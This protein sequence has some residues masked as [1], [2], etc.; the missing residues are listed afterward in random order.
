MSLSYDSTNSMYYAEINPVDGDYISFVVSDIAVSQPAYYR[1][2]SSATGTDGATSYPSYADFIA[3]T[4]GTFI[5]FTNEWAFVDSFLVDGSYFYRTNNVIDK[6]TRYP[7]IEDMGAATNG[8]EYTLSQTWG[9]N[10]EFFTDG[11]N[12]YR[13]GS[14]STTG[15]DAITTHPS[16][17]DLVANTNGVQT[18]LNTN[19][20]FNDQLTHDGQYFLRTNVSATGQDGVTRYA[21]L[22]DFA[23]N[24]PFDSQDFTS[25]GNPQE[26]AFNDDIYALGITATFTINETSLTI[27]EN[28]GTGSFTIV[29]DA[30]PLT[31]V[32]FDISSED[33]GEATVSPT[34]LTFTS[35]D[36]NAAQTVTVTGVDDGLTATHTG[37]ITISVNDT[38]SYD[39]FDSLADKLVALTLTD[40]DVIV[41]ASPG[42]VSAGLE[43]W[44]K[45]G[46]GTNV[47]GSN[48]L[49][50][51]GG[52]A[53]LDQSG[54]ARHI[55]FIGDT[56]QLQDNGVNFN[57]V[58]DWNGSDFGRHDG[59]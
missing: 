37:T 24:I 43:F 17:T 29:L 30:Q 33:T 26:W 20:S 32:V 31:D 21:S 39:A 16:F 23:S 57:P 8:V 51:S 27:A 56:P 1:G 35:T 4:N 15:T 9:T 46:T 25:G 44:V 48:F 5:P 11:T 58:I 55:D 42:G 6:I 53:W 19:W 50:T 49:T 14:I 45:A 52:D 28:A 12:F 3:N 41:P 22:A 40:D 7:S 2:S 59:Q 34:T 38:S 10:D 13:G 18:N 54:N 36:W 47:D